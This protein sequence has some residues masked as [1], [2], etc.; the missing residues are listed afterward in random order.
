MHILLQLVDPKEFAKFCDD[1]VLVICNVLSSQP[2]QGDSL[3]E[4]GLE[5]V[6]NARHS[7][8]IFS[9]AESME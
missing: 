2:D 1:T 5:D 4:L 7:E 3:F 8:M 6:G 9:Q